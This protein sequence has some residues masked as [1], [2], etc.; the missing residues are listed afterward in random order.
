MFSLS[1]MGKGSW[2]KWKNWPFAGEIKKSR[3]P[4]SFN[5]W[6][7][8]MESV[9]EAPKCLL[10]LQ[11]MKSKWKTAECSD[12]LPNFYCL[13]WKPQI[14]S[15]LLFLSLKL[16]CF[17]SLAICDTQTRPQASVRLLFRQ[18]VPV[19]FAELAACTLL[20]HGLFVLRD[21]LQTWEHLSVGLSQQTEVQQIPPSV[22]PDVL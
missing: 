3:C 16:S 5:R 6:P 4:F 15:F 8:Q 7:Q 11:F 14:S 10:G 18:A 2:Q 22:I 17:E 9:E 21:F 12:S 19:L 20:F 1:W 13:V